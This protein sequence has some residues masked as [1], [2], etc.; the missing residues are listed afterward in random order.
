MKN[1]K[2]LF[3]RVLAAMAHADGV[4]APEEILFITQEL[5]KQD[6]TQEERMLIISDLDNKQDAVA[7][8]NQLPSARAKAECLFLIKTIF[9]A[10]GNFHPAEEA[11]YNALQEGLEKDLDDDEIKAIV[12]A[13]M[14][15][16]MR[17]KKPKAD[18]R[19]DV[20]VKWIA[21]R[22]GK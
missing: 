11:L 7:L 10:D 20:A 12:D 8:F 19:W 14:S 2:I 18:N 5:K 17:K 1:E 22:L 9:N 16:Y 13:E 21:Q 3:W 6:F 15:D 4:V